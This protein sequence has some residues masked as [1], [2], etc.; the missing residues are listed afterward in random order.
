MAKVLSTENVGGTP[1][2]PP[3]PQPNPLATAPL[4][5]RDT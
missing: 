3:R 1:F 2:A 4:V 5:R